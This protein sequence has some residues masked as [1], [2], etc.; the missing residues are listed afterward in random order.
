MRVMTFR[1][2]GGAA[3]CASLAVLLL[4]CWLPSHA[5][6]PLIRLCP[7]VGIQPRAADFQPGGIILTAF[8]RDSLWVYN[9]DRETRYPLPDTN[10]CGSNCHLSPDFRWITYVNA[11]DQSYGKMRL[12]GTERTPLVSYASDV[13]WWSADTLLVWT[14]ARGAYLLPE[15]GGEREPLDVRGVLKIQPGGRWGV[16]VQLDGDTFKRGL[17]NLA[18]RDMPGIAQPYFDLGA[19]VPYFDDAAWSPDGQWFAYVAPG[20]F[21][22]QAGIAG[23]EIFAVRPANGTRAQWTDLTSSYGAVRINGRA[24]GDLRWS[25][26]GTR[27][28]FWV[29]ELLGPDPEANLG[30]AMIHV[31]DIRSGEVTAYCGFTTDEHTPNPPRLIWSP[32]GTHL[33]FG[34]NVP[35]DDKGYLL[36]ALDVAAGTFTALSEGI[37]P[38]VGGPNPVAW[39]YAP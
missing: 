28:A 26:D 3:R 12:D 7:P 5:M 37:Y 13:E 19:D 24:S 10:P 22:A 14:P 6:P 8:D 38:T 15:N 16:L 33:A 23:G 1:L 27:L 31:L 25:P 32:D 20:S 11:A 39:G 17:I 36:L 2:P 9:I 30:S 21:D 35:G 18:F 4:L 34:G 29:T